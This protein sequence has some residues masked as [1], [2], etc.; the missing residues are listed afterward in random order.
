MPESLAE[1]CTL[2]IGGI[3]V[4]IQYRAVTNTVLAQN[5]IPV[6]REITV[7]VD[8]DAA[9]MSEAELRITTDYEGQPLFAPIA[10]PLLDL[11]S[12]AAYSMPVMRNTYP[13]HPDL[14]T[15]TES[16]WG[17]ITPILHVEGETVSEELDIRVLA[18]DEWF[19]H[20]AYYETLAA[21]VQPNAPEITPLIHEVRSILR[22]HTGSDSLEGYQTG[23]NRAI[24]IAAAIFEA[25]RLQNIGYINPP[26]SFENTGQRIRS[27]S[28]VLES[29]LGTCVDLSLTFAAVAEQIG[30]NPVV[31]IVSGHATAGFLSSRE[32]LSSPVVIDPMEARNLILSGRV[33][34]IEATDMA[35]SA[36]EAFGTSVV[37]IKQSLT[38]TEVLGIV[39]IHLAH[40]HGMRPLAGL[41]SIF[42][43]EPENSDPGTRK[44]KWET[45]VINEP[46]G[47]TT[48]REEEAIPPRVQQWKKELLDLSLKNR[49]LNL[50]TGKEVFEIDLRTGML[51]EL[52]DLIHSNEKLAL[53]PSDDISDNQRE[54]GLQSIRD[55]PDAFL[56]QALS[57][58]K[59]IYLGI[60]E[61]RYRPDLTKFRRSVR[62]LEE[63]TGSANLYLTLGSLIHHNKDG[64]PLQAPLFLI[65]VTFTGGAGN[66]RFQLKVDTTQTA[67]P[68]YSLV[69]WLRQ[70]HHINIDALANPRLDASGLDINHAISEISRELADAKLPFTVTESSFVIIAKFT[71]YGMWKDLNE[72]WQDF[73]KAPVFQHLALEAG[74]TF[75]DPTDTSLLEDIEIIESEM[76][77]PIPADGAQL[78]AVAAAAAGRS[79]V[80]EGPPGT[81]K[82]QTITN[83][84]AHCLMQGKTV[85][86][87]AEK[88]AA[89]QVVKERLHK[90]GLS[91]FTLDLHGADQKPAAIRA[92][93]KSAIDAAVWN[94][95]QSWKTA[96]LTLESRLKPFQDY[97]Q[98]I[99]SRNGAGQSLWTATGTLLE[100]GDGPVA[101]ISSVY[102][103]SPALSQEEIQEAVQELAFRSPA[104]SNEQRRRWALVGPEFGNDG[105]AALEDAWKQLSSAATSVRESDCFIDLINSG[106]SPKRII[107]AI[108]SFEQ[109]PREHR[110]PTTER[111][112]AHGSPH[113]LRTIAAE[114]ERLTVESTEVRNVFSPS[115]LA[116]GDVEGLLLAAQEAQRGFFGRKKRLQ[117]YADLL[118]TAVPVSDAAAL[119]LEGKHAPQAIVP[120]LRIVPNVRNESEHLSTRLHSIPAHGMPI[121]MSPF[122]VAFPE[123]ARMRAEQIEHQINLASEASAVIDRPDAERAKLLIAAQNAPSAWQTWCN[124]LSTNESTLEK[125]Q[126]GAS[127]IDAWMSHKEGWAKDIT[128]FGGSVP[129]QVNEWNTIAAPLHAS[130]LSS[131]V[132]EC[133]DSPLPLSEINLAILRGIAT[134]SVAERSATVRLESFD[135]RIK[136]EQLQNLQDAVSR[137]RELSVTALPAT[138]LARRSFT[139][140]RLPDRFALLRRDLEAKRNPRSF[141]SLLR[142]FPNEILEATPCFFV[143]PASLAT[144]VEP[145]AA[146]FDVVVFDEASQVTVEQAMGALG[147]GRSAVIVGDS[148]QMPPTRIGKVTA[149]DDEFDESKDTPIQDSESILEEASD[150]GMPKLSLT[151]H[152]RSKDESLIA[153]SNRQYYDGKLASLPSPGGLH[154]AGVELRR[155][156]GQFNRE[157]GKLHRTNMAEAKAIVEEIV[158]RLNSPATFDESIGV[159]TFNL[160]QCNLIEDLLDECKDPMVIARLQHGHEP[161]FVKNLENV[162][163]DERD[164]ILFS[165]AFS[166]EKEGGR[167]PL[168]FGPIIREGGE[169]RLN[170]AIT[171][172]RKTVVMFSSFAPQD[173]DLA[174]TKS[175]GLADLRAYMELAANGAV[176]VAN[177]DPSLKES[178]VIRDD[179][180]QRLR[181]RGLVTETNY[182]LSSFTLDLVVRPEDDER[183]HV[184]IML[185]SPRWSQMPTVADRDLTPELLRPIMNWAETKR[186]WLPELRENP[187][188]V[189]DS[190]VEAVS[191]AASTI[192]AADA[193]NI[194]HQEEAE[195][196]MAKQQQ[197]LRELEL[198]EKA[199][200]REALAELEGDDAD[201]DELELGELV[202]D[203]L[204]DSTDE[205]SE[206]PQWVEPAPELVAHDVAEHSQNGVPESRTDDSNAGIRISYVPFTITTLG[207]RDELEAGLHPSRIAEVRIAVADMIEASGPIELQKLR[208]NIAKCFGRE[209][210]SAKLNRHIDVLIPSNQIVSEASTGMEFV[211]PARLDP[212]SWQQ[213]RN[214]KGQVPIKELPLRELAN[215][216]RFV[217]TQYPETLPTRGGSQES[218]CR[219]TAT[220]LGVSRFSKTTQLRIEGA[221]DAYREEL[222]L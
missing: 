12:G 216:I 165:L 4:S 11:H 48:F 100:C 37:K 92:Q 122:D 192:A 80:L 151:W 194:R 176:A 112:N 117:H 75:V 133:I 157:T 120:F 211:W 182:G 88:Q 98:H 212:A 104:L 141:R 145:G 190:I 108:E 210:T 148:K 125:W 40:R 73:L 113:L 109:I 131:L 179:L 174:R 39:D 66:S 149:D 5:R 156:E 144:F 140:S 177:D 7:H 24:E 87:V 91:P 138:L 168:N 38:G 106:W 99:H 187:D 129:H 44:I 6:I 45:R 71:T 26:A 134:A 89:L 97:P 83:L 161:L 193:E 14:G 150:S 52:D 158:G 81:G 181:K 172:A 195:A 171:R 49:L 153:F 78:K 10:L 3:T 184:A 170:V 9:P 86:F 23:T 116:T 53:L 186:V 22:T 32:P 17:K 220:L 183:W 90:V 77:L 167:L 67:S 197:E 69:E 79:F 126:A 28:T 209:R 202:A 85:L 191:R 84:V 58:R 178:N 21:F 139:A 154:G 124:T 162:Q 94:D 175:K 33:I 142:E 29:R 103:K 8:D 169:K 127:W 64:K 25:L 34:P 31:I 132:T 82:S 118:S 217:T 72:H 200:R 180:A 74:T 188:A 166:R 60:T 189:A 56:A 136:A 143:S 203:I 59:R 199:A 147:R 205:E 20:H 65:P 13:T 163:G 102:V 95:D 42:A 123:H 110:I 135:G 105:A 101:D 164:V 18:P 61:T 222:N 76:T 2:T 19:N 146:I 196:R 137:I 57:E 130:G 46:T 208:V 47:S 155:I 201:I 213:F 115:F 36:E 128:T 173:I 68:N 93:L 206:V 30:L 121:L 219:A 70:V 114:A 43:N 111:A 35:A 160:Q 27:S 119:D 1:T 214:V 51:A 152:Y 55:L 198:A 185:D 221:I 50:R 107:E 63:E 54:Q 218:L 207:V 215:A 62:T 41:K 96:C 204:Y 159:V 16:T 15:H